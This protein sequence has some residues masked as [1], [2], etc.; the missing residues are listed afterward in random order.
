[1]NNAN[2]DLAVPRHKVFKYFQTS[3]LSIML[4]FTPWL[5]NKFFYLHAT[6]IHITNVHFVRFAEAALLPERTK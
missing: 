2:L 5:V 3:L 1:M 6:G 4:R